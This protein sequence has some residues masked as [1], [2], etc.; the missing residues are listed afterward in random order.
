MTDSSLKTSS[1]LQPAPGKQAVEFAHVSVLLPELVAWFERAPGGWVVD[2]TAGGAGH[3]AALLERWPHL[4][5]VALDRD[6][7]AV[8]T[9][10]QRLSRFGE[11]AVVRHTDFARL[12]DI[13]TGVGALPLSG[14][15]ADLG[16]SSHHFDTDSRGFSFSR[17][18]PL[19]MRMDPT[20]GKPLSDML[21]GIGER[22]L[23]DVLY[24]YGDIRASRRTAAA[25]L[26]AWRDGARTTTAL[27]DALSRTL[28]R[29]GRSHP[30]TRVFQALRIWVND[31]LGQ[32]EAL[33]NVGPQLLADGGVMAVISFHS[34][35]DRMVKRAFRDVARGKRS[36]WALL[37]KKPITAGHAETRT[38]PRAR[39]A[40]LRGLQRQQSTA[41]DGEETSGATG[42]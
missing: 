33:L 42:A 27:S 22:E 23:A 3:S 36:P 15:I 26:G 31:E 29:A 40:K 34:G 18:G 16:V 24:Q 10:K 17:E 41:E 11:R 30:A 8:A 13:A 21:A 38:N 7:T 2:C 6:P 1:P 5:V 9:A 32:L 12:V 14:I 19:D 37:A 25:V 39:S 28:P 20:S 4:K 35:E